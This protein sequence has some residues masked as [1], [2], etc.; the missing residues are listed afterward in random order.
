MAYEESM[1]IHESLFM[2]NTPGPIPNA[3]E[4][5]QKKKRT[6]RRKVF[7]FLFRGIELFWMLIKIIRVICEI[8]GR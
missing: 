5:H 3:E 1:K 8:F 4:S 2:Q 7:V 6:R